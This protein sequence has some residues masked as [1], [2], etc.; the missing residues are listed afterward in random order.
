MSGKSVYLSRLP[1]GPCVPGVPDSLEAPCLSPRLMVLHPSNPGSPEH[2]VMPGMLQTSPW[3]APEGEGWYLH[4]RRHS[5]H[6]PRAWHRGPAAVS[7][8]NGCC[9]LFPALSNTNYV[10]DNS[11]HHSSFWL[12]CFSF[13]RAR[14]GGFSIPPSPPILEILL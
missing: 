3:D 14:I 4:C 8:M 11:Q 5:P 6:L 13:S 7:M 10:D 2:R 9:V 1:E 12:I